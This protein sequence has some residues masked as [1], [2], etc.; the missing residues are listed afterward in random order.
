VAILALS[1]MQVSAFYISKN[2]NKLTQAMTISQDTIELL[3]S[4]DF[5]NGNLSDTTPPGVFTRYALSQATLNM[6]P[7][8][9]FQVQWEVDDQDDGTKLIN[10]MTTW[11]NRGGQRSLSLPLR[12]T[13]F[14]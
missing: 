2:S 6:D 7:P 13:T 11:Q 8:P 12:R 14:Q 4:I 9:G 5:S 1:G 10:V 3:M